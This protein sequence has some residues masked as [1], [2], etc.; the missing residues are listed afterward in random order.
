M[1]KRITL[2]TSVG[3]ILGIVCWLIGEKVFGFTFTQIDIGTTI[4]NR[5]LIGFFIAITCWKINSF[6]RGGVISFVISIHVAIKIFFTA[7][8]FPAIAFCVAGSIYGLLIEWLTD[9]YAEL[10]N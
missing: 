9:K 7:G 1:G 2:A 10:P 8:I 5:M 4:F 6:L 3:F